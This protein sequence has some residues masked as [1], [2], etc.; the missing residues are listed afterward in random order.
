MR[1]TIDK[2]NFL[3]ALNDASH[4]IAPK[5][6]IAILANF[7]I[8]LNDRGLEVTGS[9]NDI[10]V[11]S[12]VPYE[13][14]GKATITNGVPGNTLINAHLLLDIVRRLEGENVSFD[15]I[16]NA[17]AKID[18]GHTCYKL[19][20]AKGDEYPDID[21]DESAGIEIVLTSAALSEL[22]N[23][24]AFAASNKE[25]R[26]ALTAVNIEVADGKITATATDSAR[27]ARKTISIDSPARLKTNIPAKSLVE[28]TRLAENSEIVK[29]IVSDKKVLFFFDGNVVSSRLIPG[30]YP[31]SRNIIPSICNYR[32]QVNSQELLAAMTRIAILSADRE[33]VVKLSMS[34][35]HVEVSVKSDRHGSG[36]ESIKTFQ[37][38]GEPLSVSFNSLFVIDAIKALKSEDVT[39]CFQAEMRPFVVK[40]PS[41]ESVVELI[42]PMRTY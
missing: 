15:V 16:D 23:Q 22:V 36:N 30:D 7:K 39:I 8:E 42:T 38:E 25:Q 9:N 34:E 26:P 21:L 35:D 10:T 27:L 12:F 1:L 29:M 2:E 6:P 18:D 4:A 33:S 24:S 41:D 14:N 20:C 11:R 19:N 40:N 17:V 37:Y 5:N 28:I 13:K 31:V 3:R 32:L